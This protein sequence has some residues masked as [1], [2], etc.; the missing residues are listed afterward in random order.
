MS[1]FRISY[2]S[3]A[4]RRYVNLTVIIPFETTETPEIKM[5]TNE[6]FKTLYLLHGF[7][8]C[9]D[10]WMDYTKIRDIAERYNL[11]VVLPAGEN[12][13]YV[14]TGIFANQYGTFVGKE[15]V[16]YTRRVFPLSVKREDTF[17]G[18]LSMGGF[19]AMRLG[20]FYHE[21]F[22]KVFSFSGAFVIDDISGQRPGYKDMIAD[23]DYYA[24]TFGDLDKVKES[25]KNP[26]WCLDR[27]IAAGEQPDFYLAC[28]DEDF[29]LRENRNMREA[30]R[31]RGVKLEY[32]ESP[33]IHNWVFWNQ[34]L[35]KAVKWALESE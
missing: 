4:L 16:D 11:A 3:D 15:I 22:S 19:G 13:F 30:L 14:D 17:I 5:K 33:G 18:G 1:V 24:R 31:L 9:Q 2:A 6:K 34:Y 26:L 20:C 10:D 23:Y 35:E 7:G 25:E 8:G 12:S 28:G 32:H 27:A 29:L 21:N